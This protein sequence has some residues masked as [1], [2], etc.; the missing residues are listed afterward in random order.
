VFVLSQD[1]TYRISMSYFLS[2]HY[3]I[4]LDGEEAGMAAT[5]PSPGNR[6]KSQVFVSSPDRRELHW[7]DADSPLL[8][9]SVGEAVLCWNRRWILRE[10]AERDGYIALG[11]EAA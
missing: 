6:L 10:R 7:L 5:E 11:L 3:R 9:A 8:Q 1:L 4:M 2:P